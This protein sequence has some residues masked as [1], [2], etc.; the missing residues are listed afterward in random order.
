MSSVK[1]VLELAKAQIG[2][3]ENPKH[4]NVTKFSTWYGVIGSWCGMWVSWVFYHAG[5]PLPAIQSK[6]GFAYCPYGVKYFKD[7]NSWFTDPKKALPGD[8]VFFDWYPGTK[9]SGAYHVGIVETVNSD[10]SIYSIEG[11]T[12]DVSQDN[13]GCVMRKYRPKT[14]ILGY[15]R[16]M[17]KDLPE[18]QNTPHLIDRYL[19]LTTPMIKGD[20]VREYQAKLKELSY[21]IDVDGWFGEQTDE[22]TKSFQAKNKLEVDGI[23][24][25]ITWNKLSYLIDFKNN[26]K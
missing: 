11:N 7:N 4:S 21:K 10:G 5:M 20:D 9:K 13:G 23:V 1:K 14:V 2:I 6:K 17:Y 24:G 26:G 3:E 19:F 8:I 22:V 15:A 16:P 12:G 18:I 25:Q